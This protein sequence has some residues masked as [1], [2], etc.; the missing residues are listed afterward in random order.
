MLQAE[1][2]LH[3]A[4]TGLCD[5]NCKHSLRERLM[6]RY[7]W[8]WRTWTCSEVS[9]MITTML[10]KLFIL[11]FLSQT[12]CSQALSFSPVTAS[13]GSSLCAVGNPSYS[14]QADDIMGIPSGVPGPAKCGFYCT[15]LNSRINCT[16]FNCFS[17]GLCQFFN[18]PCIKTNWTR[19]CAYYQVI[20]R[21]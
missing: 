19:G 11:V 9:Y 20:H 2:L 12:H 6:F 10:S 5:N 13:N 21:I 4:I 8:A 17:S 1:C 18:D 7:R 15:G 16:G 14:I 3:R